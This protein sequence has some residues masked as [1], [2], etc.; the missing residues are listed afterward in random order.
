MTTVAI[1]LLA[2]GLVVTN[3]TIIVQIKWLRRV[4]RR[5]DRFEFNRTVGIYSAPDWPIRGEAGK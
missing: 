4:E 3:V 5:M 2:F 1:L